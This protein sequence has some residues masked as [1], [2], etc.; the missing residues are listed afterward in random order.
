[1]PA[2][3]PRSLYDAL[4]FDLT[5]AFA[6]P[7]TPATKRLIGWAFGNAA[8]RVAELGVGLDQVVAEGGLPAG[9]RWLLPH[10]VKGHSA[11]GTE[12][13]PT[14]GPL[15]VVSNHPAGVDSLVISSYITHSNY[16]AIID[17]IPFF[18]RLPHVR[19]RVILAPVSEQ[20]S[21]RIGTVR[22][23]LRHLRAGGSLL[24]FARGGIEADPAFMPNPDG[25]FDHWSR[26]LEI[27]LEHVP[28][29]RVLVT[30][31]SGVIAPAS[32]N[33]V[34]TR[35]R[36]QRADRQRI[37]FMLQIVRQILSG[38]ELFQL[39]PRVTFG[40]VLEGAHRH[41]LDQVH[42]SARRVLRQHME[43]QP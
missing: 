18:E 28:Q 8:H 22:E 20:A 21:A 35:L 33:N 5:K 2:P 38:R 30:I 11:R 9:G 32:M 16:K 7:Q 31:V 13:I 19:E 14:E 43:W 17:D 12:I 3:D 25:E 37:A 29:T 15:V 1:M 6:L 34:L 26:S 27:F 24:V 39:T 4:I 36:K 42:E 41:M 23:S 40:E 10:F